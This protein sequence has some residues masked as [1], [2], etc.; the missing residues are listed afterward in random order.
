MHKYLIFITEFVYNI[1]A[2]PSKPKVK[3][4]FM[5]MPVVNEA[6]LLQGCIAGDKQSWDVFVKHFSRLIYHSIYKTLR[7]H[8][9]QTPPDDINDLFQDIF[10]AFCTDRCKKLRV[11]DP[12]KGLTL[13]SWIRM[14]AVRMTIDHIRKRR[15]TASLDDIPIAPSQVGD[16]E[17]LIDRESQENLQAL[18]EELPAK[19]KLLIELAIMRELPPEEV[20]RMLHISVG[21][22]YTRKNRI[23]ERLKNLIRK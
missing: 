7:V 2:C 5:E 18:L 20:A 17:S 1:L 16:Q 8:D 11:F 14:I 9:K 22:F 3:D 4:P 21:A 6:K 10:T 19:D 12:E 23:I 15:D 13:S